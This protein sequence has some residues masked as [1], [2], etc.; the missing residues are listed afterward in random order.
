MPSDVD[1][2]TGWAIRRLFVGKQICAFDYHEKTKRFV[3]GF[4][5]SSN[6]KLP[7]DELHPEWGAEGWWTVFLCQ[8][9]ANSTN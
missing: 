9:L 7:E 2:S 1:C 3:V 5:E 6:F 8:S 4:N